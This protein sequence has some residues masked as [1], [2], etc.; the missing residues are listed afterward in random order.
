MKHI[1]CK[2]YNF[3]LSTLVDSKDDPLV[4]FIDAVAGSVCK[5]CMAVRMFMLGV[6]I[7]ALVF[8]AYV[9][10][11]LIVVLPVLFT[12]GEKHWLCELTGGKT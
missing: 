2:F 12:Y 9:L 6:G 4:K 11:F 10:G 5:Y 1:F 7:T 8:G 3:F